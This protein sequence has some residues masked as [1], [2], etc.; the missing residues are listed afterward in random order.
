M[1]GFLVVG[2]LHGFDVPLALF[3][4]REAAVEFGED[5]TPYDLKE[6][7][8]ARWEGTELVTCPEAAE[9]LGV[10]LCRFYQGAPGPFSKIKDF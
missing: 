8:A 6:A 9:P 3:D 7:V 5:V 1:N 4:E 10:V 2:T